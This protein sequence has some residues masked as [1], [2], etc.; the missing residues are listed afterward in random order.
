MAHGSLVVF[1]NNYYYYFMT[2]GPGVLV[3]RH[4]HIKF[5]HIV[6]LYD[7]WPRSGTRTLALGVII[8]F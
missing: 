6:K 5:C 1:F 7:I 2:P 8:L 4:D 3:L